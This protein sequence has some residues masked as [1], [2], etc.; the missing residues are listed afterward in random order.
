MCGRIKSLEVRNVAKLF[1]VARNGELALLN[2]FFHFLDQVGV[3]S[4]HVVD[5]DNKE[6]S[7][8]FCLCLFRYKERCYLQLFDRSRVLNV[9]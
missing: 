4:N 1:P 8:S 9:G 3:G 5:L 6:S 7:M 2:H